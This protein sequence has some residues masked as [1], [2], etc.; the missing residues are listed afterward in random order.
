MLLIPLTFGETLLQGYIFMS[1]IIASILVHEY[2][3]YKAMLVKGKK[4][5]V[6]YDGKSINVGRPKDYEDMSREDQFYVYTIGVWAGLLFIIPATMLLFPPFS[7]GLVASY[8]VGCKH[9]LK[10]M[11]R[12]RK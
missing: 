12:L 8:L 1:A 5:K 3:H 4:V 6:M 2:G 9:D 7:I 11:W 10:Q